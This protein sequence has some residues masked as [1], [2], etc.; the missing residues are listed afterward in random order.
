M[1]SYQLKDKTYYESNKKV[2]NLL[3]NDIEK[4]YIT[5]PKIG[6]CSYL[7]HRFTPTNYQDFLDKYLESGQKVKFDFNT[8]RGDYYEGRTIEML[9]AI[10][11]ACC[12]EINVPSITSDMCFDNI[13]NHCIIE[14]FDGQAA[15][16]EICD[17]I[18]KSK[19]F[20]IKQE[21]GDVD[22]EMGVDITITDKEGNVTNFIQVK[23]ISTFMG[24]NS[25]SLKYDRANFYLKQ[26]KLDNYLDQAERS[27]EKRLIEYMIYD[28]TEYNR[29]GKVKFLKNKKNGTFRF[30]LKELCDT[31]GNSLI[32][33]YNDL[34]FASLQ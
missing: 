4:K 18:S 23:P 27:E 31:R 1:S 34:S 29:S 32:K 25:T 21:D 17:V 24:N 8:L 5:R 13:I 2:F 9:Q 6:C 16:R 28:K 19:N 14:T 22:T 26:V 15:E 10:A 33:G 3:Y 11:N 7:C 12:K 30:L 20:S